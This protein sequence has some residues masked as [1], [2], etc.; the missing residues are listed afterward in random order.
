MSVAV[1]VSAEELLRALERRDATLPAE[2]STFLVLE[3]CESMIENGPR[4]LAGLASVR[5]SE[6]G[7]V[8]LGGP[9]CDDEASARALH[10]LL[11]SLL[12]AAGPSLPPALRALSENGPRGGAFSLG[13]LR[14]ELEAALVPLNRNASRRVL[15]RFAREAAHPLMASEDV[16]AALNSLLGVGELPANDAPGGAARTRPNLSSLGREGARLDA[17]DPRSVDLFDGLDM[18]G[19]ELHYREGGARR[20]LDDPLRGSSS[21]VRASTRPSLLGSRA[22]GT[23][24]STAPT[25]AQDR[26]SLRSLRALAGES[27][28]PDG[29]GSHKLLIGFALIALAIA[30]VLVALIVRTPEQAPVLP[31]PTLDQAATQ[32][33]GG[34]LVVH[35]V[36]PNAQVLRFVGRAPTTVPGLPVGVAHEFVATAEGHRPSRVLVP[37][38]ADWEATAE[39]ARYELALQLDPLDQATRSRLADAALELG[40]SRLSTQPAQP[41]TRRGAV[42]LVATPRGARVYQLI[43]FSPAV[44]VQDLPLD[45]P[46]ELLIYREG[47]TPVVRSLSER[48]FEAK[49]GRRIAEVSVDLQKQ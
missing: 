29:Q 17:P 5:V 25:P 43:G 12:E 41:S 1:S 36:Q 22:E 37:G 42:R 15:S 7:T 26:D 30:S 13:A 27:L 35:V 32:P 11:S 20:D 48:D 47:Y 4:E 19:E 8:T 14:D 24:A 39:G 49:G 28:P 45:Q 9:A 2:I 16:D 23:S 34:D 38:N 46:Q 10:R 3:G 6:H 31:T 33:V 21:N 44:T 40:P 18:G